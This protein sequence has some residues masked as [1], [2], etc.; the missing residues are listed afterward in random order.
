MNFNE[1]ITI[2]TS[3]INLSINGTGN[4]ICCPNFKK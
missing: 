3:I 4:P 1:M 2:K